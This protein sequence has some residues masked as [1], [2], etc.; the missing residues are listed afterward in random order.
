MTVE[1]A[2][3]SAPSD[4]SSSAGH[5]AHVA[6][7]HQE[8]KPKALERSPH[9]KVDFDSRHHNQ[10]NLD[11]QVRGSRSYPPGR[12][13]NSLDERLVPRLPFGSSTA[14]NRSDENPGGV[15]IEPGS[16]Q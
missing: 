13:R 9:K 2:K 7:H 15:Q 10:G 6:P 5:V 12:R 16:G 1:K 14:H 4:S 11:S 8:E 3:T